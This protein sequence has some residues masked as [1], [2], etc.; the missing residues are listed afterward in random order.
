MNC[1]FQI[2]RGRFLNQVR[3]DKRRRFDDERVICQ[4]YR[5]KGLCKINSKKK[6]GRGKK[7]E[8][9][10]VV[11]KDSNGSGRLVELEFDEVMFFRLALEV[12]GGGV[13]LGIVLG[14]GGTAETVTDAGT[15]LANVAFLPFKIDC[16]ST[17]TNLELELFSLDRGTTVTLVAEEM[18]IFDKIGALISSGGGLITLVILTGERGFGGDFTTTDA[19]GDFL[20]ST[21]DEFFPRGISKGSFT[22][23]D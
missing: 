13:G 17:T 21:V 5:K 15:L 3:N 18:E 22:E 9:K 1:F 12:A 2:L 11:P 10:E 23:A 20:M 6:G 8:K 14:R 4:T 19:I 16:V 7:N